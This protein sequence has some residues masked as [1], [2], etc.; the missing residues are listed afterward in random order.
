MQSHAPVLTHSP[1]KHSKQSVAESWVCLLPYESKL[2]NVDV[3]F[4]RFR[5]REGTSGASLG[6]EKNPYP[7]ED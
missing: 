2:E 7:T 4:A 6:V 1:P 5:A 3:R